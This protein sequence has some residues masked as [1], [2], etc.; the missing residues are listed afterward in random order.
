[1]DA[2]PDAGNLDAALRLSRRQV[3]QGAVATAVSL[4]AYGCSREQGDRPLQVG[5]LPV[6]CN[7]TLPVA[8]T[9]ISPVWTKSG[10][11]AAMRSAASDGFGPST[12]AM[13]AVSKND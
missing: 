7:L 5:G 13:S 9:V 2:K 1:M 11:M 12:S 10:S 4:G 8:C 3:L 6:T